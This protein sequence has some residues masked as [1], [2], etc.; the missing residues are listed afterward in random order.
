MKSGLL[1]LAVVVGVGTIGYLE[2]RHQVERETWRAEASRLNGRL[3]RA[4]HLAELRAQNLSS[5]RRSHRNRKEASAELAGLKAEILDAATELAQLESHRLIAAGRADTAIRDLKKQVSALTTI[6]MDLAALD[7]RRDL[8]ERDVVM[9]EKRLVEAEIGTVERK[10]QAE[11]L[12]R[13]I[14]GLAIRREVLEARLEEAENADTATAL[15]EAAEE[16]TKAAALPPKEEPKEPNAPPPLLPAVAPAAIAEVPPAEDSDRTR[17]LYQFSSLSAMPETTDD[18]KP[19]GSQSPS[20]GSDEIDEG[21]AAEDWAEDQYL[22]GLSLLSTAEQH[23]GTRELNDAILAFK[24]VLGEWPKERDRM[25]WAIARSD[26]GYALALLG[27]RQGS[28]NILDQ[29]ATASRDA[30]AEFKQSETPLLWAAA[31]YHLGVSLSGLADVQNDQSLRQNSIEVLEQ[32]IAT[33]KDAGSEEDARKATQRLREAYAG[34][35]EKP[36]KSENE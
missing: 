12:D 28:A 5:I 31:Q 20:G 2:L 26:L 25:R 22:L 3:E 15:A 23:S 9:V 32:A 34:L 24:A 33:F 35:P 7:K 18:A 30:L 19:A 29:A 11:R 6:E 17:G 4:E 1:F 27:R 21:A 16:P 14:A 8:L 36:A 10:K 13:A